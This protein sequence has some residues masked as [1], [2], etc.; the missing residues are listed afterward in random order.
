MAPLEALGVSRSQV[1]ST[2]AESHSHTHHCEGFSSA[3]KM[4]PP[5]SMTSV[6]GLKTGPIGGPEPATPFLSSATISPGS[7]RRWL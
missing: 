2:I 1:L 6:H 3:P 7:A 4:S 5:K